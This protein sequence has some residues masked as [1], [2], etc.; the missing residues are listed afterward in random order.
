MDMLS[1]KDNAWVRVGDSAFFGNGRLSEHHRIV[2]MLSE[3]CPFLIVPR[4][5]VNWKER[6]AE[7][8]QRTA[9]NTEARAPRQDARPA[10]P[11]FVIKL[12]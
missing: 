11:S 1:V 8:H 3:S 10:L 4:A 5:S 2:V 7:R 9:A 12:P 6:R